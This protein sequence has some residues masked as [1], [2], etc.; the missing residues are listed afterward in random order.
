MGVPAERALRSLRLTLGP[1][2]TPG[3]VDTA[4]TVVPEAV[5]RLRAS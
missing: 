5:A 3:D 4:L 1:T 2:T